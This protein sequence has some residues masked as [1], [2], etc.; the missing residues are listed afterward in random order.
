MLY[1]GIVAVLG[2][3]IRLGLSYV[4]GSAVVPITVI[5]LAAVVSLILTVAL[6]RP[7]VSSSGGSLVARSSLYLT[8][9]TLYAVVIIV[10]API[11]IVRLKVLSRAVV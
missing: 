10:A 9:F 7:T 5:V 4:R 8:L 6:E 3:V 1:L 11:F 2:N